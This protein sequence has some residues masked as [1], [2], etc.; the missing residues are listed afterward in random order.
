MVFLIGAGKKENRAV[1]FEDV[2]MSKIDCGWHIIVGKDLLQI[3]TAIIN[4]V[5]YP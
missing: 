5:V 4:L 2:F 1:L 3:L